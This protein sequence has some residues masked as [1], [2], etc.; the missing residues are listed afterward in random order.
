MLIEFSNC[1]VAARALAREWSERSERRSRASLP[2][3]ARR[4][5]SASG[6]IRAE[7]DRSKCLRPARAMVQG[8]G[9]L[10]AR[11]IRVEAD[12]TAFRLEAGETNSEAVRRLLTT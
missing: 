9:L 5:S 11:A 8:S 12:E 7:A 1:R 2:S 3:L 4:M 10:L 6:S